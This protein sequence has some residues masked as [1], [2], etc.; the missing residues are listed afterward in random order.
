[1]NSMTS[2]HAAKNVTAAVEC[3]VRTTVFQRFDAFYYIY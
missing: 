3:P 2:L 1:M